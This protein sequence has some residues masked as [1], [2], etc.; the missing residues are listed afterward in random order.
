MTL[1]SIAVVLAV[2]VVAARVAPA[3][4]AVR[5]DPAVVLRE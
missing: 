3:L 4:R 2:A 5:T 1:V